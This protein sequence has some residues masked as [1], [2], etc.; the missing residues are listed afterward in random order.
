MG[1]PPSLFSQSHTAVGGEAQTHAAYSLF[2]AFASTS[3][4]GRRQ[5]PNWTAAKCQN[6]FFCAML[7]RWQPNLPKVG[8]QILDIRAQNLRYSPR[9]SV[10]KSTEN[11][12]LCECQMGDY[13]FYINS[14]AI[15]RPLHG[16]QGV[17]CSNHSVP[18]IYS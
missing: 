15:F 8:D 16:V 11:R 5:Q 18:T 9:V 2:T 14:L 17:E 12:F 1:N 7:F 4:E 13:P 6:K 10:C 3:S